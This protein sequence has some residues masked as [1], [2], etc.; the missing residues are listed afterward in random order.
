MNADDFRA[1]LKAGNHSSFSA[2]PLIG[3]SPDS[4]R[5]WSSGRQKIPS[6]YLPAIEALPARPP[7]K[8]WSPAEIGRP[9][10]AKAPDL[11]RSLQIRSQ[12]KR[13]RERPLPVFDPVQLAAQHPLPAAVPATGPSATEL[14][15]YV[16]R[17]LPAINGEIL[18][19]LPRERSAATNLP[20]V[21]PQRPSPTVIPRSRPAGLALPPGVA[22]P[23]PDWW[24]GDLPGQLYRVICSAA[25]T[26]REDG[27]TLVAGHC[28]RRVDPGSHLC[29]GHLRIEAERAAASHGFVPRPQSRPLGPAAIRAKPRPP[30]YS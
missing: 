25:V 14:L 27:G 26:I 18:P 4:I 24:R 23:Y 6:K 3:A 10:E 19:P 30:V 13:H 7:G 5:N 21:I 22:L 1:R 17:A 9:A 2:S 15:D 20:A 12:R 29:I 28:G 11:P 16:A 8:R